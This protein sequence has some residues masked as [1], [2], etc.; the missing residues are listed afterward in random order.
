MHACFGVGSSV[1]KKNS[2]IILCKLRGVLFF[3]PMNYYWEKSRLKS[4]RCGDESILQN[5][6]LLTSQESGK[7]MENFAANV[8]SHSGWPAWQECGHWEGWPQS[9]CASAEDR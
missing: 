3:I 1:G 9:E 8:D 2:L 6:T 4:D 7:E 5:C